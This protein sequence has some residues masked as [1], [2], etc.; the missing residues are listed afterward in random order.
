MFS[1]PGHFFCLHTKVRKYFPVILQCRKLFQEIRECGVSHFL[2]EGKA[3]QTWRQWHI[4]S[5]GFFSCHG[6]LFSCE[7]NCHQKKQD[8]T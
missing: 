7:E 4:L 6:V 2:A 3:G 5:S 1:G 8:G